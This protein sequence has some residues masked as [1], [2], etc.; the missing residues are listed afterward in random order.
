VQGDLASLPE[1]TITEWP[2]AAYLRNCTYHEMYI[3]PG[4]I[5]L[6]SYLEYPENEITLYPGTFTVYDLDAPDLPEV[7]KVDIREGSDIEIKIDGL[8]EKR[9][10]P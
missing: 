5:T 1:F 10:C 4:E 9:K 8:G 3:L 7:M 2:N 6:P